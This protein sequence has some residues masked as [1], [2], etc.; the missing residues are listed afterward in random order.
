MTKILEKY[1]KVFTG[2]LS[3]F[4]LPCIIIVILFLFAKGDLTVKGWFERVAGAGV[5]SHIMSLCVFPNI[6]IFLIFNQLDMLR[7]AKGVLG[8]TIF[9][10][11]I[12][13]AVYFLL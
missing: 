8:V 2:V 12:V 7:A 5:E 10:A 11:I 13:F 6:V 4:L 9:W 1:D 3:G